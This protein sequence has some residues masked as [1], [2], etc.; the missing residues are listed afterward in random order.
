MFVYIIFIVYRSF[1]LNFI[2]RHTY[3]LLSYKAWL[4]VDAIYYFFKTQF[5]KGTLTMFLA[6]E[7]VSNA[8]P[9]SSLLFLSI[10]LSPHCS[11]PHT[12]HTCDD[13]QVK[14]RPGQWSGWPVMSHLTHWTYNRFNGR[15]V[16]LRMP[17]PPNVIIWTGVS[18]FICSQYEK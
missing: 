11:A 16:T 15:E 4:S 1:I 3:L 5:G 2:S 13:R 12:P 18:C 6:C 10:P 14:S 7:H 8:L 17:S 9:L